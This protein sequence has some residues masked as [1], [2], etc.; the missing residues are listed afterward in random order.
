MDCEGVCRPLYTGHVAPLRRHHRVHV[1]YCMNIHS[2]RLWANISLMWKGCACKLAEEGWYLAKVIVPTYLWKWIVI[3]IVI[4]IIV[5]PWW[6][7]ETCGLT[8]AEVQFRLLFLWLGRFSLILRVDSGVPSG[9]G[10]KPRREIPKALQN[11]AKL[12]PDC[13]NC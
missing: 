10:F 1:P 3:V 12:K 6:C 11:R 7:C 2:T 9:L 13:E 5:C 8:Y 4:V